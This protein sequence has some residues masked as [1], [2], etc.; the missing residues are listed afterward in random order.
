MPPRLQSTR[1]RQ[2]RF[3]LTIRFGQKTEKF[4]SKMNEI[5]SKLPLFWYKCDEEMYRSTISQHIWTI[6]AA[7]TFVLGETL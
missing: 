4:L 5:K 1:S 7:E 2:N 3:V 6:S